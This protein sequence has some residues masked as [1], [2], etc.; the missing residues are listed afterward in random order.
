MQKKPR[1][2]QWVMHF[3]RPKKRT[4]SSILRSAGS[5]LC[6]MSVAAL[7]HSCTGPHVHLCCC[8]RNAKKLA[9]SCKREVHYCAVLYHVSARQVTGHVRG[10]PM[11]TVLA[12]AVADV[13]RLLAWQSRLTSL[14]HVTSFRK[15]AF[16]PAR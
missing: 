7:R 11:Q 16:Q 6:M 8:L 4:I 10:M 9:G 1:E 15:T 3:L 5:R 2:T 12:L 13:G 14:R